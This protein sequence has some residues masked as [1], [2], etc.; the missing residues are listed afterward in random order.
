MNDFKP[1]FDEETREREIRKELREPE[2][3]EPELREPEVRE[4]E[5]REPELREPE[6]REPEIREGDVPEGEVR[7]TKPNA[8]RALRILAIVLAVLVLLVALLPF[9]VSFEAV[10]GRVLA[11][12]ESALHR[13][14]EAG[15]IRLRIFPLSAGVENVTVRN[16]AGSTGMVPP[17]SV[18]TRS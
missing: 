2:L 15:R 8:R 5:L 1:P 12:A 9:V 13:K 11:A 6:I 10:R 7:E 14:V 4:P 17:V 16:R 3:R 18:A